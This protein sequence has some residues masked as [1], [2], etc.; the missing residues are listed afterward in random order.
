MAVVAKSTIKVGVLFDMV[1]P[2]NEPWNM[3]ADVLDAFRLVLDEAHEQGRV[4]RPIEIVLREAEGLP[5]GT[6]KAAVDAYKELIDEGCL[7]VFGPAISD[8]GVPLAKYANT[9]GQVCCISWTGNDA[10]LGEY[11]FCLG[12][13]SA[14][15]E[16]A[17]LANI[18]AHAGIRRVAIIGEQGLIGQQYQPY[19]QQ[20]AALEGLTIAGGHATIAAAVY[21]IKKQGADLARQMAGWKESDIEAVIYFGFGYGPIII[22]EALRLLDWS[23]ARYTVSSWECG[24]LL[25]E[26]EEAYLGWVGLEQY[27]EENV[28]GQDFLDRFEKKYGRRPEYFAPGYAHDVASIIVKAIET[29][30]PLSADGVKEA[31]ENVRMLPAA[32]GM[33]GTRL[34]FG[35]FSR[36]GWVGAGF[37]V[38]REFDPKNRDKTIFRGRI[39]QPKKWDD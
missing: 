29:A 9:D 27:D 25:R 2:I 26:V 16:P 3:R 23:P 6:A 35:R 21:D 14:P 38:A 30:T 5:L 34:S 36:R 10:Y 31:L 13:G 33:P 12:N 20:A 1:F 7:V 18:I 8:N 15:D 37:M 32:S 39:G 11:T 4:D 22:N 19:F 24:F 17:V 28:V